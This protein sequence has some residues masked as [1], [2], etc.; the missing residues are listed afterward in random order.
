MVEYPAMKP[1]IHHFDM[2]WIDRLQSLPAGVRPVM[3]AATLVGQPV[4]VGVILAA[5]ATYFW[6]AGQPLLAKTSL[7]GL[8]CLP[9]STILKEIFRRARPDTYVAH[10]IHNY[11]FPSGH[12]FADTVGYGLLAWLAARHLPGPWSVIV[13]VLLVLLIILVGVSRV[14]L[15][16][17][18]PSDVVGGWLFGLVILGTIIAVSRA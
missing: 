3:D 11:S 13:P 4:A 12:A 16:A 6:R 7:A 18:Y 5:F 2:V 9:I 14:Y 10:L 15:G 17:H 1:F 8:I